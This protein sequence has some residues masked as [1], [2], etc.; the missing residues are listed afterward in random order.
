MSSRTSHHASANDIPF[1]LT[2]QGT[3]LALW[4][5]DMTKLEI[6]AIV[7]A[8]NERLMG[9]GGIDGAIHRSAGPQLMN[10]CR[11]L[12]GCKTG[13]TKITKGY[14]LPAKHVLHTV[15][16]IGEQPEALSSCY[17]TCLDLAVESGL[18]TVCFC[19]VSTGI[20]GVSIYIPASSSFFL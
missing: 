14:K 12:G 5:G 2:H 16:P 13:N 10:E 3:K 17:R 6:D 15:G 20:Y 8:A 9:G 11:T 1:V 7:N 18:K 4:K 19:C